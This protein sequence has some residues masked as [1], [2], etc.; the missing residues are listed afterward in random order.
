MCTRATSSNSTSS[1]NSSSLR[2]NRRGEAKASPRFYSA[3]A[4]SRETRYR[5]V[6]HARLPEYFA[7]FAGKA[8]QQRARR[9]LSQND[10]GIPWNLRPDKEQADNQD[11]ELH[12]VP[13]ENRSPNI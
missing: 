6:L 7:R 3:R 10:V 5:C 8:R 2:T 1:S 9:E 13:L 12:N 11:C 4:V